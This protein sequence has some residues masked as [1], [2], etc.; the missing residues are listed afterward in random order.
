[1]VLSFAKPDR[2]KSVED[3]KSI[4]AD[5]APPGVYT[6]NM[7]DADRRL[8]KA[9]VT[10]IR[11]GHHAI[12]VRSEASG[13]NVLVIVSGANP[14]PLPSGWVRTPSDP[15][16][17]KMSANGPMYFTA[18]QWVNLLTAVQEARQVLA[19]L[20]NPGTHAAAS[21]AIKAGQHP[22]EM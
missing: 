7:S 3:W 11:S 13:S 18:E 22:L 2:V 15:H 12:E 4:S 20:D 8:W 6:S 1:M 21:Q 17:I 9:K 5:G 19:L 16:M 10:G 14:E